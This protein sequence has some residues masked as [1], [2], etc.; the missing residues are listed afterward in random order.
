MNKQGYLVWVNDNQ[1]W[2]SSLA[3]AQKRSRLAEGRGK[4]TLIVGFELCPYVVRGSA[5]R[6]A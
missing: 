3:A 2:H 1:F 4:D 6:A 5:K